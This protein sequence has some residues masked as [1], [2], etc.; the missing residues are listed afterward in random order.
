MTLEASGED[1][2]KVAVN[3]R[4]AWETANAAARRL[5][6]AEEVET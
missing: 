2:L 1:S 6:D 5:I 3:R 4:G